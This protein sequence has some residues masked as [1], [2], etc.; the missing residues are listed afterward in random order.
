M[1]ET[2][3]D[4][5]TAAVNRS[6]KYDRAVMRPAPFEGSDQAGSALVFTVPVL[7]VKELHECWRCRVGGP[8]NLC[9]ASHYAKRLKVSPSLVQSSLPL[10]AI[11]V[12]HGTVH[13]WTW[14]RWSRF[15]S[16]WAALASTDV[17]VTRL[18]ASKR[19]ISAWYSSPATAAMIDVQFWL[20]SS[21]VYDSSGARICTMSIHYLALWV[22]HCKTSENKTSL[23]LNEHS[24]HPNATLFDLRTPGNSCFDQNTSGSHSS[25]RR[26]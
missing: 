7:H 23:R 6:C 9:V 15:C 16:L 11:V 10:I 8:N 3:A 25:N 1:P 19:I 18:S 4:Q 20:K 26:L 21:V 24:A 12:L 14:T 2:L 5:R 22:K 13:K 17:S